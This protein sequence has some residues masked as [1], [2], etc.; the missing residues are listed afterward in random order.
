MYK[1]Y[2][3]PQDI[4]NA[5]CKY[6]VGDTVTLL[7]DYLADKGIVEAGTHVIIKEILLNPQ[8]QIIHPI[9]RKD[10][11]KYTTPDSTFILKLALIENQNI[12]FKYPCCNVQLGNIPVENVKKLYI[13]KNMPKYLSIALSILLA[14][15]IIVGLL[16]S[17]ML[18]NDVILLISVIGIAIFIISEISSAQKATMI[19]FK[20]VK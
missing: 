4:C 3:T 20:K 18:S 11:D 1:E 9:L 8:K 7:K 12:T 5:L 13:N 10:L 15:A 16:S 17:V 6:K 14:I 19:E 2:A